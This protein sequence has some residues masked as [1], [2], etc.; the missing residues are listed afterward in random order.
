MGGEGWMVERKEK[1][2]REMGENR[3]NSVNYS[4]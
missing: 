1:G 2:V 3:R 4:A